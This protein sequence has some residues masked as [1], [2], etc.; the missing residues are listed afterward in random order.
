LT[1]IAPG[2]SVSI[3]EPGERSQPRCCHGC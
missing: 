1:A 2:G 3:G